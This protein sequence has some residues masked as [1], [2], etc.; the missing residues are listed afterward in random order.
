[1]TLVTQVRQNKAY[2]IASKREDGAYE[3][4]ADQL[5][6]KPPEKEGSQAKISG[7]KPNAS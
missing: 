4:L 1:L 5:E 3:N 2:L 7:R 6:R